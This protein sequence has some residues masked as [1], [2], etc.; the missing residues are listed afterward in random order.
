MQHW[1]SSAEGSGRVERL[2]GGAADAR[3]PHAR[4]PAAF[5]RAQ[6][7]DYECLRAAV[8]EAPVVHTDD[9]GWRVGGEPAYLMAFE[10]EEATVY[11]IWP[12][13]C[14]EPVQEVI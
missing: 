4:R 2:D 11:Q 12:R 9:T 13:H 7:T 8:P 1:D 6:G 14:H 3:Y 10:A 5:G